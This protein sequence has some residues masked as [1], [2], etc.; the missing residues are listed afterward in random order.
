MIKLTTGEQN[1]LNTFIPNWESLDNTN[2]VV[3]LNNRFGFGS[4]IVTPLV[5]KLVDVVYDLLD[6]YERG[7]IH[8]IDLRYPQ[9][10]VKSIAKAVQLFDRTK[11]LVLKLDQD[12]Y[13]TLID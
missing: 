11:Y 5:D 6:G 9:A 12:A 2:K 4:V 13:S 8:G 3:T 7:N 1:L 10:K